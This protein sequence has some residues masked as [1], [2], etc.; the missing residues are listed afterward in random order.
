MP[1]QQLGVNSLNSQLAVEIHE[2]HRARHRHGRAGLKTQIKILTKKNRTTRGMPVQQLGVDSL[3]SQ[4]AVEI[5]E[6]HRARHRHGR[7]GL[8]HLQ[9]MH[10]VDV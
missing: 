9:P 8:E 6:H 7:A 5:H 1:V 3:D 4:L 10:L 2:H